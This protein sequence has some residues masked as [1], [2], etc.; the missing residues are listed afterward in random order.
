MIPWIWPVGNPDC[1]SRPALTRVFT[2]T[3]CLSF[4]FA[5]FF[6]LVDLTG[7]AFSLSHHNMRETETELVTGI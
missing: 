6:L 1:G 3:A 4:E 2:A 7:E 5:I